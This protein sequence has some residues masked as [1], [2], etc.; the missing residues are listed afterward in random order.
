MRL[1]RALNRRND[2]VAL[3]APLVHRADSAPQCA[4]DPER[5]E[6][7]VAYAIPLWQQPALPVRGSELSFPVR[8]IY[9]VGRNYAAHT[10]EMGGDPT[11]DPPFFF[12]KPADALVPEG[13]NVPYPPATR[14]LHHEI[15]LVVALSKGGAGIPVDCALDCIFGYGVG[16]DLTRRDLQAAARQKGQPW[17]MA[18]GFD[19][20]APCSALVPVAASGHPGLGKI[21][22][23]VNGEVR[24]RGD[25]ADM[26]WTVA[27]TIACLSCLVTLAPGDLIFTGTPDGVG[28]VGRGDRLVGEVEG[29]GRLDVA[30]V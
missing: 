10:R 23:S 18:K 13:G 12:S 11:R 3:D 17:D 30:L 28:A 20:S 16:L 9:C 19:C 5:E 21:S 6:R 1:K 14:D 8:R 7:S 4:C 15:E 29:I 25:L 27:E 26:I 24:Q 22:L 2:A